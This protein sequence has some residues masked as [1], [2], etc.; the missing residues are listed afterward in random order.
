M[1]ALRR[2]AGITF[3]AQLF[4]F[5]GYLGKGAIDV[6]PVEAHARCLFLDPLRAQQRWH[7]PGDAIQRRGSGTFVTAAFLALDLFPVAQDV[8]GISDG[9]VG[10]HMRMPTDQLVGDRPTHVVRGEAPDLGC[11]LRMEHHL[12]KHIPQFAAQLVVISGV[13]GIQDLVGLFQQM[14]FERV[15]ILLA[16]PRTAVGGAQPGHDTHQLM[17]GGTG[18]A[19]GQLVPPS[20]GRNSVYFSLTPRA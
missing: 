18:G 6:L 12:Q 5:L 17:E 3:L 15:V 10:E 7:G 19:V 11:D 14:G 13:D 1:D 2:A 4:D 16:I 9:N 8:V 20:A